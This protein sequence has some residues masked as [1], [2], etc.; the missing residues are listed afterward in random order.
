MFE[1][2]VITTVRVAVVNRRDHGGCGHHR[3]HGHA[4]T[5]VVT[6]ILI[7]HVGTV[8]VMNVAVTMIVAIPVKANKLL[9][10]DH[11]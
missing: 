6:I 7:V 11:V 5:V 8:V 10:P 3:D 1:S 4:I 9:F 2:Y